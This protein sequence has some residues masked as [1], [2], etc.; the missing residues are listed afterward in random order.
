MNSLEIG[1]LKITLP[2][3]YPSSGPR[4]HI[5]DIY[6]IKKDWND[7]VKRAA[8][9]ADEFNIDPDHI[10]S[11]IRKKRQQLVEAVDRHNNIQTRADGLRA[12]NKEMNKFQALYESV[13]VSDSLSTNAAFRQ[14]YETK[15]TTITGMTYRLKPGDLL[16][17]WKELRQLGR[18]AN[19]PNLTKNGTDTEHEIDLTPYF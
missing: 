18:Q 3:R 14:L 2:T 4:Y 12:I 6:P 16:E 13:G 10:I 9:L 7:R 8:E 15:Q 11:A 5:I 17:S 19:D 1:E